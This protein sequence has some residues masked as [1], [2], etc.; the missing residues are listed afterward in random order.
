MQRQRKSKSKRI[1]YVPRYVT[2]Y[3][4]AKALPALLSSKRQKRN[5]KKEKSKWQE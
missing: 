3:V 1:F 5:V 4:R 2:P